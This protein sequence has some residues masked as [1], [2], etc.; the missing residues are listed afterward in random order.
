MKKS[1]A[2][3]FFERKKLL[4]TLSAVFVCYVGLWCSVLIANRIDKTRKE[5]AAVVQKKKFDEQKPEIKAVTRG[6]EYLVNNLSTIKPEQRLF[7]D[8]LQRKFNL[9][10]RLGI[11]KNP[12]LIT[13]NP[14]TYPQEIH[15]LARIAYP[16][17]LVTIPPRNVVDGPTLTNIYSANCDHMQL[18]KAFWPTMSQNN[19]AGG[20]YLTHNAL[21]LAFIKDNGCQ[22]P[23]T[24]GD[25]LSKTV[26]GMVKIMDD[27]NTT[28][29]LRYEAIAFLGLSGRSDLINSKW[30][31]QLVSQQKENGSWVDGSDA[32]NSDHTTTLAL[33]ALLEYSHPG[34]PYEPLIHRPTQQP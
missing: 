20:Y 22:I 11:T 23:P 6:Q 5:H 14:V 26:D 24:E 10:E 28:P 21:A 7:V 12:I 18:P 3:P 32:Q 27:P 30:I 29:D 33:W 1:Q 31:D 8:Y 34:T 9:D 15:F 16:D 2:A 13:E 4:I 17:K 25:L 19:E